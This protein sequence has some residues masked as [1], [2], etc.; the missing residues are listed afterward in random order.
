MKFTQYFNRIPKIS[1]HSHDCVSVLVFYLLHALMQR[2]LFDLFIMSISVAPTSN[3]FNAKHNF[4]LFFSTHVML[5]Y[6]DPQS[7]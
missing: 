2:H 1:I 4:Y 5:Y 6:I 3:S 7:L